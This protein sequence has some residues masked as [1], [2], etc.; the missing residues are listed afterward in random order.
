MTE[1]YPIQKKTILVVDD[2]P[3]NRKLV[4]G[5]LA[6]E[7]YEVV[8]ASD[9]QI[10]LELAQSGPDLILLDIMMPVLDGFET[11]RLLKDDP[12]SR[13]IPVLFLSA[14]PD[15]D[16]KVAGFRLGGLDYI[17]KPFNREELMARVRTH[18]SLR[19]QELKLRQYAEHLGQMVEERTRQLIHADRLATLGT[20]VAALAHEVNNPLQ[21]VLGNA[22][23]GQLNLEDVQ[24][25]LFRFPGEAIED[26]LREGVGKVGNNL[27]DITKCGEQIAQLISQFRSYGRKGSEVR[28]VLD[29]NEPIR[30]ALFLM[31]RR[32]KQQGEVVL[33]VPTGLRV[34]AAPQRLSQVFNNLIANALDAL[35]GAP[36]LI[37]I[38]AETLKGQEI[39]VEVRDNGPGIPSELEKRIFE[40]FITSKGDKGG[41]GLGLFVVQTIVDEHQGRIS[42]VPHEGE[43]A[44]FQI[45]LP[46]G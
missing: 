25:N 29:L 28:K 46:A 4:R 22:E 14:L 15:A 42:L 2:D 40:P 35:D 11:C 27:R 23:L 24:D 45:I 6:S 39:A 9:G 20:L 1:E 38:S 19:E 37:Q 33:N 16:T 43:G 3:L 21:G 13:D 32:L 10:A 31:G 26:R 17:S 36:C 12:E 18:L 5:L 44:W 34:F 7:G 8:E 30:D 41:T